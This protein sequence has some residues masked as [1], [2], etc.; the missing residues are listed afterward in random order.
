MLWRES[1][2]TL[3]A[4]CSFGFPPALLK[5]LATSPP[6]VQAH[7]HCPPQLCQTL[8][9]SLLKCRR[10]WALL[11][12][13]SLDC[14]LP[15][16]PRT[17]MPSSPPTLSLPAGRPFRG[18]CYHSYHQ[19]LFWIHF[20]TRDP[21][22]LRYPVHGCVDTWRTRT[23]EEGPLSRET[24]LTTRESRFQSSCQLMTRSKSVLPS[25]PAQTPV[26]PCLR[27]LCCAT[28]RAT[29]HASCSSSNTSTSRLPSP[30]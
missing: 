6:V 11:V 29:P 10:R 26:A 20:Q 13:S 5:R 3:L 27:R 14:T 22:I 18:T 12:S 15:R 9:E 24:E 23:G 8:T 25:R 19:S 7:V 30:W 1:M 4:L 2:R 16:R 21:S 17:F 28:V